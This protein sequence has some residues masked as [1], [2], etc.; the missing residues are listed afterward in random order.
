MI[1]G[2]MRR[3]MC[4]SRFERLPTRDESSLF[5]DSPRRKHHFHRDSSTEAESEESQLRS[6]I[7]RDESSHTVQNR[8][9]ESPPFFWVSTP[10]T[11]PMYKPSLSSQLRI[12]SILS[13][14]FT[15]AKIKCSRL[16]YSFSPFSSTMVGLGLPSLSRYRNPSR[17][18]RQ[19]NLRPLP[20]LPLLLPLAPSVPPSPSPSL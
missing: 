14:H 18:P 15:V 2:G 9:L 7:C 16:L 8:P 5:S 10:R 20:R 3:K 13:V 4:A 12:H 1:T 19:P 6:L 17:L 11:S